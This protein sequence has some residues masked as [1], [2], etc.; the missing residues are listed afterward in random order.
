MTTKLL[1]STYLLC[2]IFFFQ[3]AAMSQDGTLDETFGT[4]GV[5]LTD[6]GLV[7]GARA[8]VVQ[9][10]GKIIVAG[11][12]GDIGAYSHLLI[13]YNPDGS[14]DES[15]GESGITTTSLGV[16]EASCEAV[17]LQEDGK[18]IVVGTYLL[19]EGGPADIALARYNTDGSLDLSYGDDGIVL[20]NSEETEVF[21]GGIRAKIQSDDKVVVLGF[22]NDDTFG[23][24]L[25]RYN[26]DGSLD[27]TFGDEG[28]V[29]PVLG[30]FAG[31]SEELNI[32]IDDEGNIF[33]ASAVYGEGESH[34][35]FSIVKYDSAGELDLTFGTD[36]QVLA[37]IS[38]T[39][40]VSSNDNGSDIA[41]QSD[42]K[43][44][45]AGMIYDESGAF[46]VARF[47]ASGV[48]DMSFGTDGV[49]YTETAAWSECTALAIQSNDKIII[50][51]YASYEEFNDEFVVMR[52][53]AD[54]ELDE[55]FGTDGIIVENLSLGD[56]YA[57]DIHIIDNEKVLVTG[58][59][60]G[61]FGLDS[62]VALVQYLINPELSV[63]DFEMGGEELSVYPNP[64][65]GNFTIRGISGNFDLQLFA[66]DGRLVYSM[67]NQQSTD[68]V[69]NQ[70]LDS[71][72]YLLVI[73]QENGSQNKCKVVVRK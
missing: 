62:R 32:V 39:D 34:S 37:N 51:G 38:V 10:D 26:T 60:A 21:E 66:L 15:F 6:I 17:Q 1:K 18:I 68:V 7:D 12:T 50:T 72:T 69:I 56:D 46:A 35:D 4:G 20:T 13:R 67:E 19:A 28:I 49:V 8:S 29:S 65:K 42:G 5:V 64:T 61:E 22:R 40:G 24:L 23:F 41:F 63:P 9:S 33:L 45:V 71:G 2:S 14:L 52:Y 3:L 16:G 44:I 36:G 31:E 55:T 48:L 54:G 11:L 59:E 25:L 27:N 57:E 58:T 47:T 43:I 70:S 30:D 53:T 73:T